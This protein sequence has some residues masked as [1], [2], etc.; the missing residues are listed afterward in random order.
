LLRRSLGRGAVLTLALPF[1]TEE[2]DIALRPAFLA[3]VDRFVGTA[4]AR[5]GARRVEVGEAWTFDGVKKVSIRRV[6]TAPGTEPRPLPVAEVDGRL[7]ATPTLAGLY[8]LTLDGES[9]T[10]VAGVPEREVDL[11]PRRVLDA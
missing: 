9:T 1:S 7:R 6:A 4:R 10:R 8:E 11:R 3:L 5:G 2:S